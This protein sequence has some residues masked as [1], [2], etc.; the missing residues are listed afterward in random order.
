[1]L[2]KTMKA[3]MMKNGT[4]VA[5]AMAIAGTVVSTMGMAV[6][7]A[8]SDREHVH[9]APV[10][11]ELVPEAQCID[12]FDE[13]EYINVEGYEP[14]CR[15][16]YV[17]EAHV[18]IDD[19]EPV[20]EITYN[21]GTTV[22]AE[23]VPEAQCIDDLNETEYKWVDGHGPTIIRTELVP[24]KAPVIVNGPAL[25]KEMVPTAPAII[26]SAPKDTESPAEQENVTPSETQA[27]SPEKKTE[28]EKV[29]L[30]KPE[31]IPHYGDIKRCYFEKG[32]NVAFCMFI[33]YHPTP[34]GYDVI[35]YM[36]QTLKEGDRGYTIDGVY[37]D[38]PENDPYFKDKNILYSA[39]AFKNFR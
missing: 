38:C 22:R 16:T 27:V 35:E 8:E 31:T 6:M 37:Y 24:E 7:A 15:T 28:P 1:M 17:P 29:T 21:D 3:K 32:P 30:S 9:E 4:K 36:E 14:V 20:P 19:P 2:N 12:N 5:T 23:L 39:D 13:V 10:Y 34:L 25:Y 33:L 11:A 18:R 26:G